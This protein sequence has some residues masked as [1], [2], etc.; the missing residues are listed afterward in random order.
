MR[1]IIIFEDGTVYKAD[2]VTEED[3]QAC[4]NGIIS[5]IDTENMKEY[6]DGQ[7]LE[8]NTWGE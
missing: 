3:K 8:L 2:K 1:Y 6:Y 4:D 5:V 7:W